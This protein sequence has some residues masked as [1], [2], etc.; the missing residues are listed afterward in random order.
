MALLDQQ[1]NEQAASVI[2]KKIDGQT[3]PVN[4]KTGEVITWAPQPGSQEA[5]LTCPI[6]EVLYTG[7]RGPGKTD[8]LLMDFA[9]H[10]GQGFGIAWRGIVFRR[11]FPEL[12]DIIAKSKKWF[13]L[14]FGERVKYNAGG[15]FWKWVDGEELHFRHFAKPDDYWSYHGHEYP[16]IGWEELTT[17]PTDECFKSMFSCNRSSNLHVPRKIR[18]T[19]NPY[20]VGFNWVKRRYRLPVPAGRILGPLIDDS[21]NA[22]TGKLES[23]RIAIHG[24][25]HEN[26]ILLEAEPDY[27]EKVITSAKNPAQ[28]KAWLYGSWDIVSGGMFDDVWDSRQ[29]VLWDLKDFPLSRIPH[30]WHIMR[31]Y[32]HGQSKP[33]SVGW[34]AQSNG[35]VLNWNG[36]SYGHIKGDMFRIREWYGCNPLKDNEGI[37]LNARDIGQGI[38]DREVDWGIAGRVEPGPADSS[39]FDGSPH[40]PTIS[41]ASDMQRVGVIWFKADK[42]RGSRSLGWQQMRTYFTGAIP[43]KF[44]Y[45]EAKGAFVFPQCTAFIRTIPCLPRDDKDQDDVDSDSEDHIADEARYMLRYRRS[46]AE[47][48]PWK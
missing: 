17:W 38:L 5:F 12:A 47:S 15:H 42:S 13:P 43:D 37:R 14:I 1:K 23:P 21:I 7:T 18:A 8:S 6:L 26:R 36:K 16:F 45:R 46:F 25:I 24:N 30:G 48:S 4:S 35:E 40:D 33:F 20:G 28:A 19:T 29:H 34:W 2:W 11:T 27:L 3:R 39:I 44:G 41:V 22:E 31:S 32:D 9:Q 10:V